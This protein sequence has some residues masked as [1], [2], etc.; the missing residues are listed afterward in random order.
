MIQI[1]KFAAHWAQCCSLAQGPSVKGLVPRMVLLGGSGSFIMEVLVGGLWIL[2]VCLKGN[3]GNPGH[4]LF[5]CF[6]AMP[7]WHRPKSI[8]HQNL[9]NHESEWTFPLYKFIVWS[10]RYSDRKLTSTLL[11]IWEIFLVQI[12]LPGPL[13][14]VPPAFFFLTLSSAPRP[15]SSSPISCD[16]CSKSSCWHPATSPQCYN[17]LNFSLIFN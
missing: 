16:Y 5:F 4:Y 17:P 13:Y 12:L 2:G 3:R 11:N 6:L 14:R 8:M 7:C 10:V 9:Q 15:P 1:C